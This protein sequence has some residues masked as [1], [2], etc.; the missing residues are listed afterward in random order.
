[1]PDSSETSALTA[2]SYSYQ[3][4]YSGDGNYNGSTGDCE[5]FKIAKADSSTA[6]V[7]KDHDGTTVDAAHPAA[8]G[9]KVHDTAT[10]TASP[11]TATGSVTYHLFTGLDC[12]AGNEIGTGEQVSLSGGAVPDSSETS[13]LTAGSYSY[14]AVYSGDGNYNGSTGDCE[15]FNVAQGSTSTATTVFDAATNAAWTG[16]ESTGAAA[17]DTA[18][19][20]ASPFTATGTVSYTFFTNGSCNGTGSDAGTVTLSAG[21]VPNSDTTAALPAGSYSFQAT[22]SGD[23]NYIGSTGPCEPFSLGVPPTTTSTTVF[24]AGTNAAWTGTESTGASA[25]DTAT[26]SGQ[27]GQIVPTGTVTYQLFS[28]LDCKAGNEIGSAEQVTLQSDGSV[29][30]SSPT[31]PLQA[32]GYS[33]QAV[34]SG[35]ANYA[36][37][38][39]DCEPFSVAKGTSSTATTVFD[40]GTN[41]PWAGTESTGASAY[42]T[43]TVSKSDGFTATGTVSYQLFSGLDC[44]AGNEIGSA[45]QVTLSGGDVPHSSA[46]DPL[47]AGDYSYQATYSGDGNYTGSTGD[48]EPFS[49]AKG[50]SS[51][52]TT[53]FDAATN[54][55]WTGT[56][57]TGA[58]AY[59]TSTVST[60]DGFIATGTVNYQLFSG[61]DCK[62]GNEIGSPE[63][64]TLN[65]DG[66]VP[67]SSATDP[68]QAGDYS[69]QATYS[70][71]GNY[72]GSTGDCEPFSVV[73][74]TPAIATTQDPASGSVG[75][76]YKDTAT[77]S[78][79]ASLDGTG[80]ITWTLYPQNNCQ[81]T[82]V[83]TDMVKGVSSNG[84]FETPTGVKVNAAGTYYWVATFSGDSNN[85]PATSGCADEPVVVNGAAIHILKTADAAS[86]KEGKDIG[87]TMTVWNSGNG[88]AHGVTLT[89]QLPA[90]P[91]LSWKV[92]KTGAGFGSSCSISSAGK[93]TCGPVTVP[94]GTTQAASTFTV[95]ITSTTAAPAGGDCPGSGEVDNTASVTTSNDGSDQ[96]TASTCVQ[97]QVDLSVTKSGSPST[98][99]LGQGNITWTIVV[100]NNGPDEDTGVVVSDPMPAGNA[101]VSATPS[102]GTCTGGPILN[103]TIGTMAAGESVT[104]TLVTTPSA[105]GAQTNTVTVS[106]NRPETNTGNNSATATVQVTAPFVPPPVFC[107]AVSKVTPKQLFVGRKTTL[108]IRVTK[109]SKAVRGIHVRITGP[110]INLRTKASN[111]KGVIKQ[112]VKMKKAGILVFSPIASK[113]CNTKRVGVT[114]V[115]TPPVTG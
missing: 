30:N 71:D 62:A 34:Y 45:E 108:T 25:Y 61:L 115:F 65:S 67:H 16:A 13:A 70:G 19:V 90:K 1:V 48:C 9:S 37:S 47:Q 96:S 4:V 51:T 105:A 84:P 36:T 6:T 17:Y 35:D 93:L 68:L 82:P 66:S 77:L 29:P 97:A 85:Q 22:Y 12:Q 44:K 42:D 33:Y 39:G 95:H 40:A 103:C 83:G 26:V 69:Y 55:A 87:F 32:G 78:N 111:G 91:G 41:L 56:E 10:V 104:I 24:D 28:G 92:D 49:V 23:S 106:G 100:T 52:T 88:D 8:L 15:P 21:N 72:T 86:V 79:T 18:T 98:Q 54:A 74:A 53:V 46:T 60:S 80:T 38:T 75:D 7:V 113:R 112:V 94:A 31:G 14:Q 110:K 64:V 20:T 3:A 59:D 63:Q 73:R 43:A 101:F 50:T 27:Q 57:S 114:N 102:R 99:E 2:G 109:H 76:T 11:F 81:G 107:V 58:S 89:D 5:P